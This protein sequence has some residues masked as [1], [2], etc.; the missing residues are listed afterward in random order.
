MKSGSPEGQ[1]SAVGQRRE[2]LE[3]CL[4]T[5]FCQLAPTHRLNADVAFVLAGL[6]DVVGN[7]QAQPR[8]RVA[9]KRLVQPNCHVGGN[10][11][12]AVDQIVERLAGNTS[13]FQPPL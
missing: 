2:F 12:L 9:T 7:L 8:L 3:L 1:G 5:G 6:R 13:R 4:G 10:A 11:A